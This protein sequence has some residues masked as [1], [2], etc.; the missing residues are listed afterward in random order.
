MRRELLINKLTALADFIMRGG[1]RT[2]RLLYILACLFIYLGL[3]AL[4]KYDILY[5]NKVFLIYLLPF[6]A[7]FSILFAEYHKIFC[8]LKNFFNFFNKKVLK[9]VI[10]NIFITPILLYIPLEYTY[11]IY[12]D[13]TTLGYFF[14]YYPKYIHPMSSKEYF[15]HLFNDDMFEAFTGEKTE[16]ENKDYRIYGLFAPTVSF[17]K[18]FNLDSQKRPILLTGCSFTYG[19]ALNNEEDKVTFKLAELTDR[20]VYNRSGA[21][22]GPS[23]LLFLL[24]QE[25]LYQTVK[26]PEYVIYF[27]IYDHINRIYK[28]RAQ[29]I[30]GYLKPTFR[31]DAGD[32]RLKEVTPSFLL[33]KSYIA[34]YYNFLWAYRFIP[35]E[36]AINDT[37]EHF[38][39]SYIEIKKHWKNTKFVI[40]IY[41]TDDMSMSNSEIMSWSIWSRLRN[42]GI[43]VL[44]LEE[45]SPNGFAE[46]S[47]YDGFHPSGEA[48]D[49][50]LPNIIERLKLNE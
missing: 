38:L 33:S 40:A 31:Y 1:V 37:G 30:C 14:E 15:D 12:I 35:L 34:N 25:K 23:E 18:D 44:D 26:E 22:W 13:Y 20:P 47:A 42:M 8:K 21:G 29:A 17:A 49:K 48:W 9:I 50:L 4:L 3:A 11:S 46:N 41:P 5:F 24:Q 39:E 45:V 36:K 19:T 2:K 16:D 6:F 28:A 43:T 32:G 7:V 10:Y 27:F